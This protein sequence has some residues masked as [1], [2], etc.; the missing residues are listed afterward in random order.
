M[1]PRHLLYFLLI[2]ISSCSVERKPSAEP[3]RVSILKGPSAIAFAHLS[4]SQATVNRRPFSVDI[5][6]SP[7]IIQ[8]RIIKGET[9]MAVL[10]M[11]SAA[12]LYNKGIPYTLLGC[13]IWGTLFLA[14]PK[15]IQDI[16]QLKGKTIHLFGRGTTPEILTRYFLEENGI[17]LSEISLNYTFGNARDLAQALLAHR[18]ETAVVSE[19]FLSMA[20]GKDSTLH[21]I[22]DL[23]NF[24]LDQKGFPQTAILIHR[25]M[26]PLRAVLDSLVNVS[27]EYA[28]AFPD[29]VIHI[30]E[31]KQYFPPEILSNES[32]G[33]CKIAYLKGNEIRNE[34]AGY[35]NI[36]YRHT[37]KAI[38]N[39]LPDPGFIPCTP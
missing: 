3:V 13:P 5:A 17:S 2:V 37:P 8:A 38:G 7:E 26:E 4:D 35:L 20:T 29:S 15:E 31:K 24:R 14:G 1:F 36:I 32:I 9:D 22:A 19:P 39:K 21:V 33:R 11:T 10:P 28:A 18:I 27:C 6:D 16:S 34:V 12:N 25:S 30:V 23:N